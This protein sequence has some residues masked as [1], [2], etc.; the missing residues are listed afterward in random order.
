[1]INEELLGLLEKLQVGD[2]PLVNAHDEVLDLFLVMLSDLPDEI[3]DKILDKQE[4]E[5]GENLIDNMVNKHHYA[6]GATD[7]LIII[8]E[9]YS[10][11]A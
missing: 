8:S 10:H 5:Y 9:H 7:A 11:S 6:K 2:K 1:M 4:E 3:H